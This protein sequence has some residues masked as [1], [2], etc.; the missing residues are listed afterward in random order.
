MLLASYFPPGTPSTLIDC[1]ADCLRYDPRQRITA[2]GCLDHPYF[3][4]A[5]TSLESKT[6]I[7]PMPDAPAIPPT[8]SSV[9]TL[10]P[11]ATTSTSHLVSPPDSGVVQNVPPRDAPL[12]HSQSGH[13]TQSNRPATFSMIDSA[14]RT[15]PPPQ[16]STHRLP[17]YPYR[18]NSSPHSVPGSPSSSFSLALHPQMTVYDSPSLDTMLA[19]SLGQG[20]SSARLRT[21]G[22][23]A[24]VD[25]LRELDLPSSE[26]SSYG[27]R[28]GPPPSGGSGLG[29]R[30]Q[31]TFAR[32][33][34]SSGDLAHP[35]LYQR[36]AEP[37]AP[38][39]ATSSPASPMRPAFDKSSGSVVSSSS[40]LHQLDNPSNGASGSRPAPPMIRTPYDDELSAP[41]P[42]ALYDKERV[43]RGAD[44][45]V[46]NAQVEA[47]KRAALAA[48]SNAGKKKKW[49]LSSVFGGNNDSKLD[50][51]LPSV[52]EE[53]PVASGSGLSLKRTQSALN[54][55][56]GGGG[57]FGG[58]I[59]MA[60]GG[61][62]G[63]YGE[64]QPSTLL[65]KANAKEA[66]KL[67]KQLELARR[68]AAAAAQRERARAVMQKRERL[69][70]IMKGAGGSG[71]G[72]G[73]IPVSN[74]VSNS[75]TGEPIPVVSPV[76]RGGAA[77]SSGFF[78]GRASSS[79]TL[80]KAPDAGKG[81]SVVQTDSQTRL[82]GSEGNSNIGSSSSLALGAS[83][84]NTHLASDIG[85]SPALLF[86]ADGNDHHRKSF[87]LMHRHKSRRRDGDDDHSMS[88]HDAG[89]SLC[90]PSVMSFLSDRSDPG[91]RQSARQYP[92]SLAIGRTASISS[93]GSASSP[94]LFQQQH[95]HQSPAAIDAMARDF[96]DHARLGTA[97]SNGAG[98]RSSAAL[99]AAHASAAGGLT[100]TAASSP[101][102]Y[103][104]GPGTVR[105]FHSLPGLLQQQPGYSSSGAVHPMF[106]VVGCVLSL[107]SLL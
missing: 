60:D 69:A 86:G 38:N 26:L 46:A 71:G 67:A 70:P 62:G 82:L 85:E 77:S 78:G 76:V 4:V 91:P 3:I 75:V 99:Y 63:G 14:N 28:G 32:E 66:K 55:R 73:S 105:P 36:Y 80:N 97:S 57:G 22:A 65:S 25:Q 104:R 51:L 41:P 23:S 103:D 52:G 1:I 48:Q 44:I 10:L 58:D 81:K 11:S 79:L 89:A 95:H 101:D 68:E 35:P 21:S 49:A 94:Q 12:S 102:P 96:T 5:A 39:G 34:S 64:G 59:D 8:R 107:L 87:D 17:Y 6:I 42:P 31:Y 33:S 98:G 45:A 19:G 2:Q 15:L 83:A 90:S 53:V 18:D 106:Q 88:S 72:N 100:P 92:S 24:L 61:G 93:H 9:P 56:S 30:G 20:S 47:A 50:H 40:S 84:S 74:S 16:P 37:H 13:G 27:R 54:G 29:T 7:P 43:R